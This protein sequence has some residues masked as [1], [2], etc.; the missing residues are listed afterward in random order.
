MYDV[1]KV[2]ILVNV[3]LCINVCVICVLMDHIWSSVF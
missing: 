3:A 1:S 2:L